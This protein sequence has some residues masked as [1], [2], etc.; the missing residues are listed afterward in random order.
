MPRRHVILGSASDLGDDSGLSFP[1]HMRCRAEVL[2][3]AATRGPTFV[4]PYLFSH[5]LA[6]PEYLI[7]ANPARLR[8]PIHGISTLIRYHFF[9]NVP[10]RDKK[11][12]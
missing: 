12:T 1:P 5:P 11:Y 8:A 7:S 3:A 2:A 4:D 6:R 10:L 9:C